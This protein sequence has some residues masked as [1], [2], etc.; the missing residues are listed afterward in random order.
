M[1]IKHSEIKM[2]V[3]VCV[4]VWLGELCGEK[5]V[6][7]GVGVGV[8]LVGLCVT[9]GLA[10]T[11]SSTVCTVFLIFSTRNETDLLMI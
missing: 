2:F 10:F 4:W 5:N 3:Y 6:Q 8:G 11:M 9:G 1:I 7:F